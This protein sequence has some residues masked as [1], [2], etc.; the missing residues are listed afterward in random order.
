MTPGR[1]VHDESH[2]TIFA[3]F[4]RSESLA[5]LCRGEEGSVVYIAKHALVVVGVCRFYLSFVLQIREHQQSAEAEEHTEI[6]KPIWR[7]NVLTSSRVSS[8]DGSRL[9]LFSQCHSNGPTL[10][11]SRPFTN[12]RS[13]KVYL[14]LSI[15]PLGPVCGV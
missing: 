14:G 12:P 8:M 5:D 7:A 11:I 10:G 1:I 3:R 9:V 15:P 13:F 4:M 6:S 2:Y